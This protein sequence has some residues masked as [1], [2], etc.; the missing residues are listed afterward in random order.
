MQLTLFQCWWKSVFVLVANQNAH[1]CMII[2]AVVSEIHCILN[3]L[4]ERLNCEEAPKE[5]NSAQEAVRAVL[6]TLNDTTGRL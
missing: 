6:I 3:E 4:C 2:S 5:A 1:I